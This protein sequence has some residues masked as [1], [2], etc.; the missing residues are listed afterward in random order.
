MSFCFPDKIKIPQGIQENL[1]SGPYRELLGMM[2][3]CVL[4][5]FTLCLSFSPQIIYFA[6]LYSSFKCIKPIKMSL[7]ED[8]ASSRDPLQ[9]T[10]CR[11]VPARMFPLARDHGQV[12]LLS[13]CLLPSWKTSSR[14]EGSGSETS[15]RAAVASSSRT[16][17]CQWRLCWS[18][19][20]RFSQDVGL[21]T[22][23]SMALAQT[24]GPPAPGM[25]LGELKYSDNSLM[26]CSE[27]TPGLPPHLPSNA[28]RSMTP[29]PFQ[30]GW[31]ELSSPSS[32][33][34]PH[35]SPTNALTYTRESISNQQILELQTSYDLRDTEKVLLT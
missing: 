31:G 17:V 26:F 2:Q 10:L 24:L 18:Q 25:L 9:R 4:F 23:P 20:R 8:P 28:Q 30:K 33:F 12:F 27:T 11:P 6:F 1:T 21:S 29:L 15:C 22:E 19:A 16:W 35:T 3:K 13:N 32:V 34:A 5:F 14:L 7:L